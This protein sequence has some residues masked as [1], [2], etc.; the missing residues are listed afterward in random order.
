VNVFDRGK[1]RLI[2]RGDASKTLDLKKDPDKNHADLQK[3][4]GKLF[5]NYP[6]Q[7]KKQVVLFAALAHTKREIW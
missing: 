4:I 2:R 1:K 6:P 7:P 3:A 5:R